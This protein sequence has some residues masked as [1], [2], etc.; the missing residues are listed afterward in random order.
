MSA[1]GQKQ[2]CVSQKA[3]SALPPNTT[4]IGALLPEVAAVGVRQKAVGIQ[5]RQ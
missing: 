5:A 4:V 2:I 1:K 3:M